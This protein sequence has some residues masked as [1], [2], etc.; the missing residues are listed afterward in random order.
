MAA[1]LHLQPAP[2][3]LP[4]L[5]YG[6]LFVL[7]L[8]AGLALW[9]HFAANAVRLPMPHAPVAAAMVAMLSIVLIAAGMLALW[10]S[11]G[12]LPM[13]AFPPPR[14]VSSGIYA[15]V[16]HPIYGGFVLLCGAVAVFTGSAAGLWLVTPAVA[17]GCSAL[18]LG[19]ELPD[20]HRRFGATRASAWL[21]AA[22][23]GAPSM[24][25]RLRIYPV[26]LL[27]W[28]VCFELISY[29]G[30]SPGHIATYMPF[31]RRLPV[32]PSLEPV[33]F[34]TYVAVLLAPL[35]IR[36]A[37]QLRLFAARALTAMALIFPLYLLLPAYVPP[38]PFEA[39]TLLGA[40]LQWERG[41]WAGAAAFPAFHVVWTC[42]V[43][44]AVAP[45]AR[46][47]R[48][49]AWIW[50]AAV[51]VSCVLTGM[52]SIA[53]VC[54]AFAAFLL[55]ANLPRIWRAILGGAERLANSWHEWRYGPIRIINHG[56]YS[57]AG[58]LLGMLIIN[59]LLGPRG[60]AV[61]ASICICVLV[62]AALWAQW[63]EGSPALLRPLGFY[64]GVIGALIGALAA[65]PLRVS[66]WSALAAFAVAGPWIQSLG[67]LRC[68]VQ[69]CC[70]GAATANADGIRYTHPR[71]RV[72]RLAHL[73]GVPIHAT[74]VYSI[75][76][77]VFVAAA[78]L[79]LVALSTP[80]SFVCGIYFLLSGMGRFVEE[81]W[82]GEPQTRIVAG[83]RFY[84]WIAIVSV[85][86][87]AVLTCIRSTATLAWHTLDGAAIALAVGAGL[88]TWFVSGVDFPE[89]NRRFARLT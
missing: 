78:L 89:S 48:I 47:R 28:I 42:I 88:L 74:Q 29:L 34:S 24:L 20:L 39:H 19:Y 58:A 68:L 71:T 73:A 53:D 9:A 63:V 84:Q 66:L 61:S 81:A 82:R 49:A 55:I 44:S 22:R 25:E 21:P 4:R 79:R 27:P 65:L 1:S 56:A 26:I 62:C 33:Y 31:E 32:V 36:E 17:L 10:R 77:N 52:H 46:G 8:P 16:P 13:N 5:L 43:A 12:G 50:A 14:F 75:V 83:L 18:V 45:G 37:I 30:P 41:P 2:R 35:L 23:A 86:A 57:G 7:V 3:L 70:H 80:A 59:A 6:V 76:W 40:W 87:G 15:L 72:C 11:G 67:R 38:R 60:A 85:I 64:G 69:G 51:A 54:A